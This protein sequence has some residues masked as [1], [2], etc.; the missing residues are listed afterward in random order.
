MLRGPGRET[1]KG[2][3]VKTLAFVLSLLFFVGCV[4]PPK[5][6]DH[7]CE[8]DPSDCESGAVNIETCECLPPIDPDPFPNQEP[9]PIPEPDPGGPMPGDYLVLGA[10]G[11]NVK[12]IANEL[13]PLIR[14]VS[15]RSWRASLF[16][17]RHCASL[18]D[19]VVFDVSADGLRSFGEES[20][21]LVKDGE[22]NILPKLMTVNRRC[23]PTHDQHDPAYCGRSEVARDRLS[24]YRERIDANLVEKRRLEAQTDACEGRGVEWDSIKGFC[25]Y[26]ID[27]NKESCP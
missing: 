25:E 27:K 4:P 11:S 2:D 21:R 17:A 18:T 3:Q 8:L 9:D 20:A 14:E 22:E 26:M 6:P 7:T 1:S 13:S 23:E 15:N 24:L 5:A 19:G 10:D 16:V 12:R